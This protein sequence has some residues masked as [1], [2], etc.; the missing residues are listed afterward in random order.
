MLL[1]PESQFT[2]TKITEVEDGDIQPNAVDIRLD[3]VERIE[4]SDFILDEEDKTHR[5][6]TPVSTDDNGFYVLEPGSYKVK[7]K[8]TISI[9][10]SEAGVVISRSTLVRNGVYLC[11]GLYDTGY[12]GSMIALLIV[13]SGNAIIKRGA[14]IGQYLIMESESNGTYQGSYGDSVKINIS[15]VDNEN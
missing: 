10:E 9:G 15:E 3:E 7:M 2:E 14:R 5:T 6:T 13:T 1:H 11:S 4:S 8:N 12:K